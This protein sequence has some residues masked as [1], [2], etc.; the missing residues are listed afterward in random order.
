MGGVFIPALHE[1]GR[2]ERY[3]DLGE[4]HDYWSRAH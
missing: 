3:R 4:W 1:R 2:G